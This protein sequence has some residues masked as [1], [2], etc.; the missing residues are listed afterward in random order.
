MR[1][2]KPVNQKSLYHSYADLYEKVMNGE[3]EVDKAEVAGKALDG[4]N[5]AFALE[6]KRSEVSRESI[7]VLEIKN[8]DQIQ[9]EE[10]TEN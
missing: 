8:F 5:R 1:T 6:I 3:I 10:K 2:L 9:V 4:M 7:R